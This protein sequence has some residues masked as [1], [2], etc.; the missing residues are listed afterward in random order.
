MNTEEYKEEQEQELV[1]DP[2]KDN[3]NDDN[4]QPGHSLTQLRKIL[5]REEDLSKIEYN[6]LDLQPNGDLQVITLLNQIDAA[7]KKI[8]ET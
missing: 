5:Y 6:L 2:F 4:E 8:V 3:A 7:V 1:A